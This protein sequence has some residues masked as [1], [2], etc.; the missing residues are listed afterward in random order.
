[1]KDE[2]EKC[3]VMCEGKHI[4]IIADFSKETPKTKE[5]INEVIKALKGN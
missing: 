2:S 1:L 4:R 5:G 3:Q